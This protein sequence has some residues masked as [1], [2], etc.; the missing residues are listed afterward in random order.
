MVTKSLKQYTD[1]NLTKIREESLQ[2]N[3]T[4]PRAQSVVYDSARGVLVLELKNRV[5][6]EIPTEL[7][8]GLAG[9]PVDQL[10]KIEMDQYGYALNWEDLDVQMSVE[11]LVSGIFG[12]QRWMQDLS[13]EFGR[14]GGQ[15]STPVKRQS[16]RANGKLGGRARKKVTA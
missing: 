15:A 6:L 13:A 16:S 4:Q 5:R 10:E 9:A 12:T 3:E 11:G 1:A 7:I 8:Q 2:Q 14:R